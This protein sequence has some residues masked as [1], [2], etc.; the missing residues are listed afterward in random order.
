MR[1][2]GERHATAA[3]PPE[4]N[5]VPLIQE[6]VWTQRPVWTSAETFVPTGIR[7]EDRPARNQLL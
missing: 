5:P 2:G 1:V 6:P 7:S 4:G 3:L